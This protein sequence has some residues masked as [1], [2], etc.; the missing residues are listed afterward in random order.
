MPLNLAVKVGPVVDFSWETPKSAGGEPI[1]GYV[2]EYRLKGAQW[3]EVSRTS[4]MNYGFED[5]P[6]GETYEFRV[7]AYNSVGDGDFAQYDRPVGIGGGK[8]IQ[9]I[10]EI[11]TQKYK[12][13]SIKILV[14]V[15]RY[16]NII[17][18]IFCVK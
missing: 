9:N 10:K 13:L 8:I 14:N 5:L 15:L 17:S 1:E 18:I 6:S 16:S 2:V 11:F 12:P 4:D 3:N 7:A